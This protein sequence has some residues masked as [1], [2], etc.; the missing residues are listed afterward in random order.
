MK[1]NAGQAPSTLIPEYIGSNFDKVIEVADNIE[2][3]KHIAGMTGLGANVYIGETP[4][5]QPKA[6]AEWYC[7]TDGRSYVWYEDVDSGQWVESSP[8][9]TAD[10]PSIVGNFFTLWKRSA[11][12]AGYNLVV[13]SFEQGGV[14]KS[15]IDVLWHAKSNEIYAWSGVFPE[16]GKIVT[17][18]TDPT[19]VSSG[20]VP[21]TDVVLRSQL[22]SDSGSDLVKAKHYLPNTIARALTSKL[23]DIVSVKDFGINCDGSDETDKLKLAIES[24]KQ[25]GGGTLYF[26]GYVSISSIEL[27]GSIV[28][29]LVTVSPSKPSIC[30]MSSNNGGIRA[31]SESGSLIKLGSSS[32]GDLNWSP[33]FHNFVIDCNEKNITAIDGTATGLNTNNYYIGCSG[34]SIMAPSGVHSAGIVCGNITDSVLVNLKI[35]GGLLGVSNAI[36]I[37]KAGITLI[38][39]TF[40]Y[41]NKGVTLYGLS[42]AQATVMGGEFLG[43]TYD[44]YYEYDGTYQ[45][46]SIFNGVFLGEKTNSSRYI[47]G[48]AS[49]NID[50]GSLNLISCHF[51]TMRNDALINFDFGGRISII[52]CY[53]L[54]IDVNATVY[55]NTVIFGPYCTVTFLNNTGIVINPNSPAVANYQ[56]NNFTGKNATTIPGGIPIHTNSKLIVTKDGSPYLYGIE[57]IVSPTLDYGITINDAS[58]SSII[59]FYPKSAITSDPFGTTMHLLVN[60]NGAIVI[61][62]VRVDQSTGY[63]KVVL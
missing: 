49:A 16:G 55:D 54:N 10:D 53:C 38:A 40:A 44:L 41:C 39:P 48:R 29:G 15:S 58:G 32:Y 43:C 4:P 20:Y 11:A 13:G 30:F 17:A 3:I 2:Y 59:K 26:P 51:D 62:Q 8:Q 34:L 22:Y 46:Q 52:G 45:N 63:L 19:T 57:A 35:Q 1:I 9:S 6:G 21:R 7:T 56:V 61:K 47:I 25:S 5:T 14:L 60:N 28:G 24:L 42:E 18:G 12:E 50:I 27:Y 31:L 23:S 37:R 36:K 33:F